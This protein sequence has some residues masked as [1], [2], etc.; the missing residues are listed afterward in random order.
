[1]N[2][3]RCLANEIQL[4]AWPLRT[5]FAGLLFLVMAGVLAIFCRK[6]ELLTKITFCLIGF[7]T[8]LGLGFLFACR[9]EVF[10]G[11]RALK[12]F[13]LTRISLFGKKSVEIKFGQIKSLEI[14][15]AG[16][17]SRLNDTIHYKLEILTVTGSKI[18]FLETSDRKAIKERVGNK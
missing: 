16:E 10:E 9:V 18:R 2:K 17:V 14:M 1:L 4:V 11:N 13:T 8:I 12:L 6:N 7:I 3:E 5:L 15:M